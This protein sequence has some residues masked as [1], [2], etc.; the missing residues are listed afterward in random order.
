MAFNRVTQ[1]AVTHQL[2]S[3]QYG[4]AFLLRVIED[5]SESDILRY[6]EAIFGDLRFSESDGGF[7]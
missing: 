4:F 7:L 5:F 3:R 1:N 6:F 2:P